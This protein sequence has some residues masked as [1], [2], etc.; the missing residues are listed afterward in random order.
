MLFASAVASICAALPPQNSERE[1]RPE[2]ELTAKFNKVTYGI[3]EKL[4][5]Q[6]EF[7]NISSGK[8]CFPKPDQDCVNSVPGY[9]STKGI[10]LDASSDHFLFICHI[11][12]RSPWPRE[13]LLSEIR[14]HWIKLA[15]GEDYV[16]ETVEAQVLLD[17]AGIWRLETTYRPPGAAFGRPEEFR[18]YIE[19]AA[20]EVGCNVPKAVVS[21]EPVSIKVVPVPAAK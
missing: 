2:L 21:A 4:L 16:S 9:L 12:A 1:L 18:R 10:P 13:T 11:D 14:N 6:V 20:R 3:R 7:K 19:S 5:R 15:P 8:L 17:V